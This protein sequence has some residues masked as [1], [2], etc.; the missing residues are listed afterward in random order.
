EAAAKLK[1]RCRR[2]PPHQRVPRHSATPI[3]GRGKGRVQAASAPKHG[4]AKLCVGTAPWAVQAE[5]SS[6]A[7]PQTQSGRLSLKGRT[8]VGDQLS[9]LLYEL[10]RTHIL[11]LFFPPSPHIHLPRLSL[12]IPN[13]QQERQLLHRMLA[14]L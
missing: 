9:N 1:S 14:N 7:E 12:F 11:G 3:V 8:F 2:K 4:T 5:R 13:D 10:A 6:A